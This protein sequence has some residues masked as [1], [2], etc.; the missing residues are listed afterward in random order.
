MYV[1]FASLL[2]HKDN[3]EKEVWRL[4]LDTTGGSARF[5]VVEKRLSLPP[6]KPKE[7]EKPKAENPKT[8]N[9]KDGSSEKPTNG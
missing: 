5:Y 6:E 2:E 1:G 7:P 9:P 3:D 8:E 4:V